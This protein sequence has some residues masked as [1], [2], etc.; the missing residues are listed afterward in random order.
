MSFSPYENTQMKKNQAYMIEGM[1]EVGNGGRVLK[2][3][4]LWRPWTG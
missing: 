4:V 2:T 1:M 3:P